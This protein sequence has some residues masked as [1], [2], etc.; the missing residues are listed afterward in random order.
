[1]KNKSIPFID[2]IKFLAAFFVIAVHF[3]INLQGS[4]PTNQFTPKVSLFFSIVYQLFITCVPLFLITTGY[5][6][7]KQTYSKKLFISLFKTITLYV[8]CSLFSYTIM[9]FTI[10]TTFTVHEI[11]QKIMYFELIKYSWYVEMY[12]GL[13]L[14]IPLF[15]KVIEFSNQKELKHFI[16]ILILVI[17][18]P[19][20]INALPQL[21]TWIHLPTFWKNLYPVLYYFIG[22]YIKKYVDVSSFSKKRKFKILLFLIITIILGI[23]INY[24]NANPTV[25]EKSGGYPSLLIVIQGTLTFLFISTMLN[26]KYPIITS[27]SKLTLPIYLMSFSVDQILYPYLISK[28]NSPITLIYFSPFIITLIFA[29][30]TILAYLINK[31]NIIIWK[32]SWKISYKINY[33]RLD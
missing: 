19:A 22:A 28:L 24:F 5:L 25:G 11:I 30:S 31:L 23:L 17:S 29:S 16:S 18:L 7:L 27:I 6:S 15:N 4:I 21:Y 33:K 8:F 13:A 3:R 26:K 2:N 32:I 10:G 12:I 1:M 14:L 20:L 9:H